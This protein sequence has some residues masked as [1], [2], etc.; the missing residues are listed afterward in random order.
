MLAALLSMFVVVVLQAAVI[1]HVRN[2][3]IDA[4]VQGARTAALSGNTAED[5]EER[6]RD[7]LGER[8]GS[9]TI[10]QVSVHEDAAGIIRVEVNTVLPLVAFLGP[11]HAMTVDGHA[12]DED[13]LP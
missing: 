7:I 5:G 8:L 1:M 13:S 3:A 9:G 6:T 12:L 10:T 4:A 11:P 2:L